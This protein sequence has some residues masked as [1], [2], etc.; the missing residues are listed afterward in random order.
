[1]NKIISVIILL[2][3]LQCQS[4]ADYAAPSLEDGIKNITSILDISVTGFTKEGYAQFKVNKIILAKGDVPKLIKNIYL[5]C[6]GGSPKRY[7]MKANTRYIVF[8]K[9]ENLFEESSYFI[10]KQE[11][12]VTTFNVGSYYR[13]WFDSNDEWVSVKILIKKM[14]K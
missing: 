13:C 5:T 1:M 2:I 4:Y 11:G 3:I 14:V 10:V 7:G 8:L 12:D 6:K 9:D